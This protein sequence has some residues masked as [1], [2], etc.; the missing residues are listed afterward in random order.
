MDLSCV[1]INWLSLQNNEMSIPSMALE[2]DT[3]LFVSHYPDT[4]KSQY[5]AYQCWLMLH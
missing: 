1:Y 3:G 4:L 2:H 5:Y